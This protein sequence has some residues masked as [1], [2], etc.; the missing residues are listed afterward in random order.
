M[1]AG[2]VKKNKQQNHPHQQAIQVSKK[3]KQ[4]TK[5]ER[6]GETERKYIITNETNTQKSVKLKPKC[7]NKTQ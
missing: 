1:W 2:R 3:K 7:A 5:K 4:G 6:E